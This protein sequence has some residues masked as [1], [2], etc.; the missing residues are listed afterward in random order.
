MRRLLAARARPSCCSSGGYATLD[1]FDVVPGILTRDRPPRRRRPRRYPTGDRH[2]RPVC[3]S[4]RAA[5]TAAP[6][7]AGRAVGAAAGADRPA[8]PAAP[9]SCRGPRPRAVARASRSATPSPARTCSTSTPATP[10]VPGVDRQAAHRP[11]RR[12]SPS[13][14]PA[15]CPRGW[16]RAARPGEIVL[17]AGGDSL[18]ARGTGNPTAVGGPG[19][20]RRPRRPGGHRAAGGAGPRPVTGA[21][22]H[23]VCRGAA[24]RARLEHGRR[25]C[26]RTPR[27]CRCSASR[28]QRPHPG[29]PSPLTPGGRGAQGAS[30]PRSGRRGITAT[31]APRP[32]GTVQAPAGA[33]ELGRV[34]S[35]PVGDVLALA[36]DD[37]DN[38]LTES[39]ARQAASRPGGPATFEAAVAHGAPGRRGPR[40]RPHRGARS[41]TPAA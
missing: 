13:T 40:R 10:R 27:G 1:V 37:S 20:A 16:S 32:P 4:R 6:L 38:A 25:V 17:V 8:A 9:T 12:A 36:L 24:L 30:W 26:R 11:R 18:L 34:E 3:P 41:R 35:A 14:R 21:A 7:D 31:A 5:A 29:K 33:A 28:R 2:A 22:R 23:D 19:R 15:R 39:L